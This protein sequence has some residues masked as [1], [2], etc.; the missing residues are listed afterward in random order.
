VDAGIVGISTAL[1]LQRDG[2]RVAIYDPDPP[3]QGCSFGDCGAICVGNV[4]PA[5]TPG[6]LKSVPRMLLAQ[7]SPL[8]ID[9]RYL[10]R[11]A[12]WLWRFLMAS[13]PDRVDAIATALAGLLA[14]SYEAYQPLLRAAGAADLFRRVGLLHVY[15]SDTA[16]RRALWMHQ[17]RER[18][19]VRTQWLDGHEV[20]QMEPA[21]APIFTRG[22]LLPDYGH[23]TNPDRLSGVLAESFVR[24]GGA[25]RR[26]RVTGFDGF[27]ATGPRILRSEIGDHAISKVVIAAGAYSKP[28]ARALG[29]K[30]PLDTERGYH[31]M[32]TAPGIDLRM[33]LMS[34]DGRFGITPMEHGLRLAGTVEFAGLDAPPQWRRAEI[35][36][37]QARPMFRAL[38]ADKP[39]FWMGRRPSL[40]DSLPVIGRS[41][42]HRNA[43][44]AFG[45]GHLGL[46]LG[47]VTGGLIADLVAGRPPAIDLAAYRP[48]RF[49]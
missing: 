33:P 35:L 38:A 39:K 2:H 37:E 4:T 25:L 47:A 1:Q 48:D 42:Q 23:V 44:F 28:L 10:P 12:P 9:W 46:T 43:F 22:V 13:R 18:L 17:T 24:G 29:C 21:L 30:V 32:L 7:D 31:A 19:G 49:N 34:G 36:I 14:N 5:A 41:P 26:A 27:T 16:F 3:G 8:T 6:I 11:L 40:P 15:R 45:R 20:A